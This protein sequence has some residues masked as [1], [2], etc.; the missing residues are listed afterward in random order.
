MKLRKFTTEDTEKKN[1]RFLKNSVNSMVASSPKEYLLKKLKGGA[2]RLIL[3]GH[4]GEGSEFL[5]TCYI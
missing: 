5:V 4:R 1:F 3:L 2:K